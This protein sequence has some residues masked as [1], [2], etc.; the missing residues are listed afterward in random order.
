MTA[1]E[2]HLSIVDLLESE[3]KVLVSEL[4]ARFGVSEM[5]I[6]R[7]LETLEQAG[8]LSRVHGGAVTAQ[9]QAYEPP[10]ALRA[11]RQLDA[12]ERIGAAAAAAAARGRDRGARRR[13]HDPRGGPR[14]YRAGATCGSSRSASTSPPYWPTSRA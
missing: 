8:A 13:H 2:R 10:F 12:K 3:G 1:P 4:S 6:R 7:D 14:A 5:T 9:S 11:A